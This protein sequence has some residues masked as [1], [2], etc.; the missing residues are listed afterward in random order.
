MTQPEWTATHENLE[1]RVYL[2]E[3]A[4]SPRENC[5]N[6]G[7]I[8][9]FHRRYRV[10]DVNAQNL[11]HY[12]SWDEWRT[13]E[14]PKDVIALPVHAYQHG[15]IALAT[16]P[17]GDPW[18]S[19]QVGFI[20]ATRQQTRENYMVKR[21]TKKIE[22]QAYELL[23]SEIE[24]LNSYFNHD[25]YTYDLL[26]DKEVIDSCGGFQNGPNMVDYMLSN[27]PKAFHALAEP[28]KET[29]K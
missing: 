10:C 15:G 17:F 4:I 21:I 25:H 12:D 19:G 16:T 8:I 9:G 22:K 29:I 13:H 27:W 11:D 2:D 20:Y 23:K 6:F 7:T 24:E 26:E 28:L 18:D 3:D 5:D 1:V 14:L